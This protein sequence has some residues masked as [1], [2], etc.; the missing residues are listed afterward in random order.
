MYKVGKYVTKNVMVVIIWNSKLSCLWLNTYSCNRLYFKPYT[1]MSAQNNSVNRL[2]DQNCLL[3]LKFKEFH[4]LLAT[5][6]SVGLFFNEWRFFAL[7]VLAFNSISALAFTLTRAFSRLLMTLSQPREDHHSRINLMIGRIEI[8]FSL[9]YH[10]NFIF[11]LQ[12][13]DKIL[14]LLESTSLN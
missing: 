11:W 4:R 7:Q 5:V 14:T 2:S 1:I 8:Q 6:C 13:G 3:L 9:L 10:C 12:L